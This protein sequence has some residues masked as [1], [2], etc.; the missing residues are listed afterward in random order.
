M[1]KYEGVSIGR[2]GDI[3]GFDCDIRINPWDDSTKGVNLKI[4]INSVDNVLTC[5]KSTT[6]WLKSLNLIFPNILKYHEVHRFPEGNL[7]V[8]MNSSER[9][10]EDVAKHFKS[11]GLVDEGAEIMKE[12]NRQLEE[13]ANESNRRMVEYAKSSG[14]SDSVIFKILGKETV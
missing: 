12:A 6:G 7:V 3:Y 1:S 8:V 13:Y 4:Y 14:L 2:I 9:S 10:P 5:S 11:N